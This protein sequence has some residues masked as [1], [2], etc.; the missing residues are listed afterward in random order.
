[1]REKQFFT[2]S[3]DPLDFFRSMSYTHKYLKDNPDYMDADGIWVF[4]GSQG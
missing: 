3:H 1:M 2:G 4:C